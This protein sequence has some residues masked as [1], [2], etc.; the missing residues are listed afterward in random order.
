[1]MYELIFIWFNWYIGEERTLQY[2][3]YMKKKVKEKKLREEKIKKR[4]EEIKNKNNIDKN[5]LNH[6]LVN[7]E[8]IHNNANM[9]K[10]EALKIRQ[11]KDYITLNKNV[12]KNITENNNKNTHNNSKPINNELKYRKTII[13]SKSK[14]EREDEIQ[15][16][17]KSMSTNQAQGKPPNRNLMKSIKLQSRLLKQNDKDFNTKFSIN[18]N[19]DLNNNKKLKT[20]CVPKTTG[21]IKKKALSIKKRLFLWRK[22]IIINIFLLF[23]EQSYSPLFLAS[24]LLYSIIGILIIF[25]ILLYW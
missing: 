21:I 9:H 6:K 15:N 22:Y 12:L 17:I 8:K 20:S 14:M 16:G 18:V 10:K 3:Q 7:N 24:P 2:E 23:K 11:K 13:S 25:I 19:K 5:F 1:M 4:L